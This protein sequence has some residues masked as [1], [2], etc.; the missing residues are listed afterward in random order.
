[1]TEPTYTVKLV[2]TPIIAWMALRYDAD[3]ANE[4][5]LNPVLLD[6]T[7]DSQDTGEKITDFLGIIPAMPKQK[8]VKLV[9]YADGVPAVNRQQ[10]EIDNL[11]GIE[12]AYDN[13]DW[14]IT[15]AEAEAKPWTYFDWYFRE[16]CQEDG[17]D[18]YE[19]LEKMEASV[20]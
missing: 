2:K 5:I 13:E 1:M 3:G 9:L 10:H 11:L 12:T 19:W 18:Y 7:S 16:K 4:V 8:V 14:E 17:V 15:R 6:R 20:A